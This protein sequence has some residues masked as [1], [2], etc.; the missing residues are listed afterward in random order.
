[1][2]SPIRSAVRRTPRAHWRQSSPR[3]GASC[4]RLYTLSG[5]SR[6]SN[7]ASRTVCIASSTV[8]SRQKLA[9]ALL[10]KCTMSVPPLPHSL[11]PI[12]YTIVPFLC[13]MNFAGGR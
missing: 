12:Q 1:M 5:K 10:M 13:Q 7:P 4:G 6:L 11:F 8:V 3:S 9:M 2:G